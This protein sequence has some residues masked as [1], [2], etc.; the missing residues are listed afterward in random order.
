L[1]GATVEPSS[2][3]ASGIFGRPLIIIFLARTTLN[4]AHR[5]VY[6]FLPTI[7]R[8]LGISL[9]AASILITLRLLAGLAAPFIGPVADRHSRRRVMEIALLVFSLAGLVMVAGNL[10]ATAAIAF[11][12]YGLSKVLYDPTV[13]AY[14]GDTVPYAQRGRAI[15]AIELSWSAAWLLGVPAAGFLIQRFGWRAP[16]GILVGL[17]LAS[18]WL[19]PIGLPPGRRPA[20]QQTIS[21]R[22]DS[23]IGAW[24][25]LLRRRRVVILLLTSFLLVTAL[26]IPF[27]VYGAWLET[28]FGLSL[29][30][31]G[32]AS[33]VVGVAE[34]CAELGTTAFTDRLGKKR[35]VLLG[36]VGLAASLAALPLLGQLGLLTALA[37]LALVMLSFEFGIVSLLPL[38]TEVAPDARATLLSLNLTAFSLG[39][40]AGDVGGGW[41]W[42]FKV[43][44]IALHAAV[45]AGVALLAIMVLAW[46]MVEI[47]T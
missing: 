43:Q 42:Q 27:V 26:E 20:S 36:L 17:G 13:Q 5:I 19:T 1:N 22:F 44:G 38:A 33:I 30:T 45:G 3:P 21:L 16:W 4:T 37:G 34:A 39:R 12:L 46:G 8:G 9:T 40:M 2:Q 15:G 10:F 24:R 28:S 14:L 41:L 35:S 31:L 25:G 7:A 23:L 47:G 11:L 18:W 6:P 32:L 29:S